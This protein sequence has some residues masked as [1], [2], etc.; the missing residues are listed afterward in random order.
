MTILYASVLAAAIG[1]ASMKL[2]IEGGH[3]RRALV[4]APLWGLLLGFWSIAPRIVMAHQVPGS[5][6]LAWVGAYLLLAVGF[7]AIGLVCAIPAGGLLALLQRVRPFR[8]RDA[9]WMFALGMVA[10][11]PVAG[12]LVEFLLSSAAGRPAVVLAQVAFGSRHQ[13]MMELAAVGMALVVYRR[14]T[15]RGWTTVVFAVPLVMFSLAGAAALPFRLDH[16]PN[17]REHPTRGSAGPQFA[18]VTEAPSNIP[19]T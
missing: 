19:S 2:L 12:M 14:A 13:V 7:G 3:F 15:R 16:I 18:R 9:E 5:G 4:W 8:G 1:L 10:A 11:L 17:G 6:A